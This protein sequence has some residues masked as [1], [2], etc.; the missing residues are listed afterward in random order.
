M[1]LDGSGRFANPHPAR[2]VSGRGPAYPGPVP[3]ASD[4]EAIVLFDGE[5]NLCQ[6]AVQFILRRD[7]RRRFRFA[8]LRSGA[9]RTALA[10]AGAPAD[11]PDSMV[12]LE[13]GGRIHLRSGAALRIARRL[14][15]P[16]PLFAVLL[17]VPR[18]LRDW[19][20]DVL[21]RR[22]LRWFGRADRCLVPSPELRSRFLDA[23]ELPGI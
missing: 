4:R 8:A 19:A 1:F 10:A 3:A 9:G 14:S 6:R 20:Y 22:R 23:D 2:R 16:W 13:G 17:A 21:A 12:L 18:P 11:L 15:M 5:C 7:R